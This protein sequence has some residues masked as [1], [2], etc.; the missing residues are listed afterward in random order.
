[1]Q[2]IQFT[3]HNIEITPTLREFTHGKFKR[4]LRHTEKITSVHVIFNVDRGR[5]LAEAR[6]HLPGKELYAEAETED[7]YKTIDSLV[8]KL[9]RQLN[10]L[11]GKGER[12][13]RKET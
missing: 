6:L 7:M 1:M 13:S 3:G 8:D 5:Q 11:K 10:K 2:Q 4:V 9:V 12:R